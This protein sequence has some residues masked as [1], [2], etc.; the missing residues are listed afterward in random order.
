MPG[1]KGRIILKIKYIFIIA[2]V[3]VLVVAVFKV[4]HAAF[5]PGDYID[6]DERAVISPDYSDT[7]IPPN[8]AP[9]NFYIKDKAERYFVR[10]SARLGGDITIYSRSAAIKIPVKKWRRLLAK[11]KGG[12]LRWEI[13]VRKQNRWRRYKPVINK[14]ANEEID[15]FLVYRELFPQFYR[16]IN[17]KIYQR[18]LENYAR[19]VIL[20]SKTVSG[21]C[22]NCHTF[23]RKKTNKFIIQVRH[24]GKNYMALYDEGKISLIMPALYKPGSAYLSWHPGGDLIAISVNMAYRIFNR[25]FGGVPEEMLE[26]GDISGDIAVY[27]I[28]TN[29]VTTTR[30]ISRPDRVETQPEWSP[31]GKYLYFISAPRVS[32]EEYEKIKYDLMRIGYDEKKNAWGKPELLISAKEAG[33]GVT[34]PKVSPDG[35]YLLFCMTDRSSFSILRGKTDL[36]LMDI[37]SGVYRK[38]EINSERTDSYHSW[39]SNSRWFAF[40]TKRDDGVF[41][42]TYF[43]YLDDE[44][45]AS[46]PFILPQKDPYF[47]DTFTGS[48]NVPELISEPV[49][50][51][52]FVFGKEISEVD[53]IINT[54]LDSNLSDTDVSPEG[55]FKNA[56]NSDYRY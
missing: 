22:F 3:I 24:K 54:R 48:Y 11:N 6:L 1:K 26:Y 33:L 34:F 47:Y 31:D 46:K 43:S 15:G 14:I 39:S 16:K 18:N 49:R 53:K 9:L 52:S 40:V 38:L 44:G 10:M 32:I 27:N 12:N 4:R 8:I 21:G 56:V 42:K 37:S 23:L 28:K 7:V 41:A 51:N 36:Y 20:D 35:K 19:K 2:A 17:M 30:D 25:F 45:N 5:V 29:I 55:N 13:F 50:V